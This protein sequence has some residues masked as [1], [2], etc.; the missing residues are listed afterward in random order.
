MT[1]FLGPTFSRVDE[2]RVESFDFD[3]HAGHKDRPVVVRGAVT[4]WPAW[5][6]WSFT[7][8]ADMC[9]ARNATGTFKNG[10]IEQGKTRPAVVQPIAPYLRDLDAA[11]RNPDPAARPLVAVDVLDRAGP[12]ESFRLDWSRLDFTPDK[13]YL[14]QWDLFGD[15][16]ELEHDL[17]VKQL[18]PGVH[19]TWKYVFFGP[20]DTLT[21]LHFDYSH[22]WFAQIRGTKEVLLFAA[23]QS[24]LLSPGQKYDWG[25]VLSDLDLSKLDQQPEQRD[26]FAR[27]HGRYV[28]LEAGDALFIPR[29]TWHAIVALTPSVSVGMFGLT[30]FEVVTR[31]AGLTTGQL[32]HSAHLYRWGNCVCHAHP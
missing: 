30:P 15:L 26:R 24:S 3:A 23:D 1:I 19:L 31:G 32:L 17:P 16:P 29:R 10:L 14:Q 11:A 4:Q 5:T 12:E 21:G 22:N 18:W 13:T 8:L 6:R 25:S 2:A 20:A 27:A 7:G 28:R 9:E